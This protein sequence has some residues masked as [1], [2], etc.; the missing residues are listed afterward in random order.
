MGDGR[1][2]LAI[3]LLDTDEFYDLEQDPHEIED[4]SLADV[5]DRLQDALLAQMDRSR[6]PFRAPQWGIR[7]WRNARELFYWSGTNRKLPDGFPFSTMVMSSP[8]TI[9]L[10]WITK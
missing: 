3:N 8:V 1:Y 10:N 2:N 5:R 6:D 7:T 9:M 4:P